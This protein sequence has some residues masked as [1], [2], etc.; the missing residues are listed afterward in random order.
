MYHQWIALSNPNSEDFSQITGYLKVSIS[1]ACTGD[2]QVEIK[3]DDSES[4]E[5]NVLMPP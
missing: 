2:D 5:D 3:E 1:V 4:K